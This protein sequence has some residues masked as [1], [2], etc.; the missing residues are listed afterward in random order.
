MRH[1]LAGLL[2][3]GMFFAIVSGLF[4]LQ[5]FAHEAHISASDIMPS[6]DWSWPEQDGFVAATAIFS[7][8]L[9]L[10][11]FLF[12]PTLTSLVVHVDGLHD[13]LDKGDDTDDG[14]V[15]KDGVLHYQ[16][17]EWVFEWNRR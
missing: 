8:F 3:L 1:S 16:E 4:I 11:V 12:S 7:L 13:P 10:F 14:T 6:S 2:S 9:C 5:Y 17:P 15:I